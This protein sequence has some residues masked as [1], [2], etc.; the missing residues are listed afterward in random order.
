[1]RSRNRIPLVFIEGLDG[2]GKSTT[3][4][5]VVRRI[6]TAYTAARIAVADSDGLS[7]FQNGRIVKRHYSSI[8]SQTAEGRPETGDKP[9]TSL[10]RLSAFAIGRRQDHAEAVRRSDLLV[11]V[12]DPFRID[13]AILAGMYSPMLG[14]LSAANRLSIF[15]K[16]TK[17]AY[18]DAIIHLEVSAEDV[19]GK[20]QSRPIEI[21]PHES[22]DN[23]SRA[24]EELPEIIDEYSSRYGTPVMRCLGLQPNTIDSA[25]DTVEALMPLPAQFKYR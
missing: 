1:M 22:V 15:D 19:I 16:L 17:T 11:S 20:V 13:A 4:R 10:Q 24:A 12:R 23:I 25:T 8:A 14:R 5:E 18:A 2:S 3:A 7:T 9:V 21:R 6:S